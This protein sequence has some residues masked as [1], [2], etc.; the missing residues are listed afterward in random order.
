[1]K[2]ALYDDHRLGSVVP[3]GGG[4]VDVTGALP[5]HDSDLGASFWVRMCRDMPELLPVLSGAADG[6]PSV[7]LDTVALRAP[8]LNPSK[9][10]ASAF[11]YAGHVDEMKPRGVSG[12]MLNFDVFL[13]APSSITDPFKEIRLPRLD[14]E[15][16]YEGELACVIGK[17][18]Y[19][20]SE[21]DALDHVAGWTILLDMTL[22]GE[23]DR[24][25]RKS[26]DGFTPMGPWMVTADEIPA[27][28]DLQITLWL[29]GEVR[30]D[31]KA[32]EMI[33]SVPQLIAHA[34]SVMTL[35]P[36][37]IIATG[38]PPGVGSVEPGDHVK[39]TITGIGTL[40]VT[41]A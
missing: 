26:Y 5:Q 11:N 4:L 31:V 20:I 17:A 15:I 3:D 1:M 39:A 8:V 6:G 29:N 2:L 41:F 10:V 28:E 23:G 27:W 19:E 36:G 34:S 9:V 35:Q 16:H 25:R 32:S 40:E 24:S 21:A 33:R 14:G 18:G 12:W 30:Q 37:D 13:K 7:A 22:R 38:A